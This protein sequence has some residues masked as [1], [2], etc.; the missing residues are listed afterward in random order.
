MIWTGDSA[1]HDNDEDYLRTERQV[2]DLNKLCVSKFVEVFG[3]EKDPSRSLSIPVIPTWGNNDVLPHNIFHPSPNKWTKAFLDI[4]RPFIPESQRHG[5]EHGGWF[6][7]EVIP[8]KLVV[9]SLNSLYFFDSNAAVDGCASKSEPGYAQFEWMRIQLQML[10]E[11]SMKA[12]I[13]GHVPPARTGGKT[14][15]DETCWQKYTLWM[16]QF[17]DVVVGSAWGHMNIAHFMLQ[18]YSEVDIIALQGLGTGDYREAMEDEVSIESTA[19]YLTELR[20]IWSELPEPPNSLLLNHAE[21]DSVKKGKKKDKFYKKIGGPFGERFSLSLVSPSVVPNYYPTLRLVEYNISGL[22][23]SSS[24]V[25]SSFGR[26]KRL[27][28]SDRFGDLTE[29]LSAALSKSKKKHKFKLPKPPS[30]TSPPGPAYSPQPLTWT[31]YTQLYANLTTINNETSFSFSSSGSHHKP[32]PKAFT[33]EVEYDTA[34]DTI[35]AM[36]DLTVLSYLKLAERIGKYKPK[37]RNP[38]VKDGDF[39]SDESPN[40]LG[41]EDEVDSETAPEVTEESESEEDDVETEKKGT[42]KKGKKK[43]KKHKKHKKGKKRK[44]LNKPWHA[45]V[46]RAFVGSKSEEELEDRF[47]RAVDED[48]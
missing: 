10:R 32:S 40:S 43:H 31:K 22:D 34:T 19:D 16:H 9:F 2:K 37:G 44:L 3:E 46:S 27:S 36:K 13:I 17:R 1:R 42:H 14:A 23:S 30:P 47:G 33:F 11:R 12:I 21:A 39:V 28:W 38:W 4:W 41:E 48:I 18:D 20:A 5:F 25:A 24:S 8:D 26:T 45:F 15:W 35:Y 7:V 29:S 6:H